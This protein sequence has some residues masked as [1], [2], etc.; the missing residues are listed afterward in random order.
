MQEAVNVFASIVYTSVSAFIAILAVYI[1]LF[2]FTR[3]TRNIDEVSELKRGNVAVGVTLAAMAVVIG[4][5]TLKAIPII[6]NEL[7]MGH[8]LNAI[9][10]GVIQLGTNVFIAVFTQFVVIAVFNELTVRRGLNQF[11]EL[12]NGNIAIGIGLA[13]IIIMVGLIL[14]PSSEMVTDVI[15]NI[16]R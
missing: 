8:I 3:L 12:R 16:L 4:L 7:L 15:T 1:G 2:T 6:T 9:I 14:Q 5:V 10:L 11:Y 13:G